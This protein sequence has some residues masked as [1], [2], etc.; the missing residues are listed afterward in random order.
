MVKD[1][2]QHSG[3][4]GS[5][6][7]PSRLNFP[8]PCHPKGKGRADD[9]VRGRFSKG[10]LGLWVGRTSCFRKAQRPASIRHEDQQGS[11]VSSPNCGC[12]AL[13][14]MSIKA[15]ETEGPEG[16]GVCSTG[17]VACLGHREEKLEGPGDGV[18]DGLAKKKASVFGT[19]ARE[20]GLSREDR[21]WWGWG[22]A[23]WEEGGD[24]ESL[25]GRARRGAEGSGGQLGSRLIL[26]FTIWL[27]TSAR[28]TWSPAVS[29]PSFPSP[30]SWPV[31]LAVPHDSLD[32]TARC[33]PRDLGNAGLGM[34]PGS[35]SFYQLVVSN[36]D[37]LPGA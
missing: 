2:G 13:H 30:V 25:A 4:A 15:R 29:I 14:L 11:L 32:S 10:G 34:G 16:G 31:A 19:L 36:R 1:I 5:L 21:V 20:R 17:C 24:E 23:G 28:D 22:A 27:P 6:T 37:P 12:T 8:D 33:C 9:A 18:T 7:I 35:S 3:T 26:P